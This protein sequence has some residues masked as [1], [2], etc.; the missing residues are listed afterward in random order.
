MG[1]C[2][3]NIIC[4][5]NCNKRLEIAYRPKDILCGNIGHG[6]NFFKKS[7]GLWTQK[8]LPSGHVC[9]RKGHE[10]LHMK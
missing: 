9:F 1:N 6:T 4:Y 10:T 8:L 7:L 2:Y 5:I 3:G